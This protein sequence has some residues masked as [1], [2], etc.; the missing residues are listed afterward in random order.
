MQPNAAASSSSKAYPYAGQVY[1]ATSASLRK[2]G[3]VKFGYTRRTA[4]IRAKEHAGALSDERSEV[5]MAVPS[6]DAPAAEKL[7]RELF[8]T[9][10]FEIQGRK[11]LVR[12]KEEKAKELLLLASRNASVRSRAVS[13]Q[14]EDENRPF[15]EVSEMAQLLDIPIAMQGEVR[16]FHVWLRR[17]LRDTALRQKLFRQGLQCINWDPLRPVFRVSPVFAHNLA[18][19]VDAKETAIEAQLVWPEKD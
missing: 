11:E 12:I 6:Q 17:S 13:T 1:L 7:L 16:P 15:C 18:S 4:H 2:K 9:K 14:V 19:F 10:G 8:V 3:L 5:L